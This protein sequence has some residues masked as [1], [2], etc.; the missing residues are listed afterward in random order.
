MACLQTSICNPWG[1]KIDAYAIA[2]YWNASDHAPAGTE[3]AMRASLADCVTELTGARSALTGTSIPLV[4]YEGGPDNFSTESL[5]ASSFQY[6]LTIDALNAVKL[7]VQ[8]TFNYYTFNGGDVWGLKKQVGD[9]PAISP[10]WRGY[11]QWL[12]TIQTVQPIAFKFEP[13]KFSGP[14]T[15]FNL[16]GQHVGA[17]GECKNLPSNTHGLFISVQDNSSVKPVLMVR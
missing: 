15:L 10:K 2:P 11:I 6:Q 3:A 8:G 12:S 5:D 14:S 17:I 1:V 9:N 4:C 16:L 7:Q 13:V